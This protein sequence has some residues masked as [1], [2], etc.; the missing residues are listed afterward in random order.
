MEKKTSYSQ[1]L[2]VGGFNP[3]EKY[4]RQIGNLPQVGMN[5]K[6]IWNHHLVYNISFL[7]S[8]SMEPPISPEMWAMKKNKFGWITYNGRMKYRNP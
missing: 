2:L 1:T 6:H 8:F 4:A 7:E 5:I 3:S